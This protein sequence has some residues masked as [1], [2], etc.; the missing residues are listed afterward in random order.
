MK[1]VVGLAPPK[2]QELKTGEKG[3]VTR[4]KKGIG[5][6]AVKNIRVLYSKFS[7]GQ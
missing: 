3:D 4:E 7:L 6:W 5:C 1:L 2:L